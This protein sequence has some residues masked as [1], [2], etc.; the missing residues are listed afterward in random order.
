MTSNPIR[1][2]ICSHCGTAGNGYMTFD[3]GWEFNCYCCSN[4]DKMNPTEIPPQVDKRYYSVNV[5][6]SS[7]VFQG[8]GRPKYND[9]SE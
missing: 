5:L 6:Q 4:V 8:S 1:S 9:R 2:H 3:N 7:N